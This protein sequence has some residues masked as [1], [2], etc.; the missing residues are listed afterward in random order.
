M[1]H[2]EGSG[3]PVLYIGRTVL[4]GYYY[5]PNLFLGLPSRLYPPAFPIEKLHAPLLSPVRA[6]CTTHHFLIDIKIQVVS[7]E[8]Y[9]S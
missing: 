4:K 1:Q 2:L 9:K 8:K 5:L 7:V 6:T 3:T